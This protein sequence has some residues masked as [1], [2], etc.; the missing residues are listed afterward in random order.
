MRFLLSL[1]LLISVAC[2]GQ[3]QVISWEKSLGGEFNENAYGM[4]ATPDGGYI[5]VGGTHSKNSFDVGDSRGFEGNGGSDFWVVKINAA[6]EILW[7]KTFGGSRNDVA[8]DIVRT[9]NGEYMV[10]GTTVSTDGEA[11]FNGPNGGL[12]LIRLREDGSLVSSRVIPGG[13][14]FNEP[15]FSYADNF[16]K[17]SLVALPSGDLMLGATREIGR[18]PFMGKQFYLARLTPTGDTLWERL[19]GTPAD[20]FMNDLVLTN[21]GAVLMV[22]SSTAFARDLPGGGNGFHDALVIKA[23]Q[24]GIELWKRAVGGNGVD[25]L[26]AG[27]ELRENGNYV[28]VGE[29]S[30]NSGNLIASNGQKDAILVSMN[31]NGTILWN[32]S[33]GGENNETYYGLIDAY[34]SGYIALGTGESQMGNVKPKGPL[35]D[36]FLSRFNR[37]GDLQNHQLYGGPDIDLARVGLLSGTE[38]MVLFGTSRSSSED[39]KKNNGENDFWVFRLSPPPPLLFGRM[40]VNLEEGRDAQVEWSTLRQQNAKTLTL[41][42]STDNK[43]F[44]GI[45]DFDVSENTRGPKLFSYLDRGIAVG[46]NYYRLRYTDQAGNTYAGPSATFEFIPLSVAPEVIAEEVSIYPNPASSYFEIRG[47]SENA[48]LKLVNSSGI[49]LKTGTSTFNNGIWKV[50]LLPKTSPGM[51]F[52][53]IYDAGT[54]K[55]HKVVVK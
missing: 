49:L 21:D 30:S 16:S 12:I 42:K 53:S 45:R 44:K 20:E 40:F 26:Y 10:V 46:I 18:S 15:T 31:Q 25:I 8:T 38:D 17:A 27:L 55:A 47:V 4:T 33:I 36:V 23:S 48:S 28:F 32:K 54:V 35:T 3:D 43:N 34:P 52:L 7:Q 39:L 9:R 50:P 11:N 1:L 6:G 24:T 13:F 2:Y 37:A 19:F 22:G 51:Y 5:L 14:N 41:E 29:T